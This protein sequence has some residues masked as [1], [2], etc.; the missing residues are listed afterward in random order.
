MVHQAAVAEERPWK[1]QQ[2]LPSSEL[3]LLFLLPANH[4][5]L[6]ESQLK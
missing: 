5:P 6:A 2:S 4:H 3:E 1:P